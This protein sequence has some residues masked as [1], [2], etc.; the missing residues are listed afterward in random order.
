MKAKHEAGGTYVNVFK[1]LLVRVRNAGG[2]HDLLYFFEVGLG[3]DF[4]P[5][6]SQ[7]LLPREVDHDSK[8]LDLQRFNCCSCRPYPRL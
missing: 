3:V 5:V 2:D 1:V 4:N 8:V 6:D 7:G